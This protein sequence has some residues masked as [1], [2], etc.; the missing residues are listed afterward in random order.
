MKHGGT[1]TICFLVLGIAMTQSLYSAVAGESGN[2]EP[3]LESRSDLVFYG[4]FE[5]DLPGTGDWREVWG[6]PWSAPNRSGEL[7]TVTGTAAIAGDKALRVDYPA[8]GVGPGETGTQWPI[9]FADFNGAIPAGYDSLFLRYYVYF[10]EGFDFVKGGKLP[11]LM[12]GEDSWSRSGGNQPDGTNGWTMRFMWRTGGEAVVY[13]YLPPGKYKEGDWG[14]DIALNRAF[15]T[16]KWICIEQFIQVNTIGNEDGKLKVWMDDELVLDLDDVLYRTVD[17]DAGKIG[18]IYVSTFHGGNTADWAPSVTS[19]AR[20]DGFVAGYNRIG[21]HGE[22]STSLQNS[23]G[24]H[25]ENHDLQKIEWTQANDRLIISNQMARTWLNAELLVTAV[26]ATGKKFHL[27]RNG[28]SY[29]LKGIPSGVY[30]MLLE[31]R[32]PSGQISSWGNNTMV[33]VQ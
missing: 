22:A 9:R 32:G 29:E 10:E 16:G 4:G 1:F 15:T 6:S 12:G 7:S 20:F 14:T 8:G 26:D 13:A 18:G 25:A 21:V 5:T 30:R 31:L 28:E 3:A 23:T 33:K 17:N 2:I 11:G 19:Y 24:G 27:P